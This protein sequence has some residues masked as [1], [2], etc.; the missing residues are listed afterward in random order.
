MRARVWRWTL[1]LILALGVAVATGPAHAASDPLDDAAYTAWVTQHAERVIAAV[2]L[3]EE[4]RLADLRDVVVDLGRLVDEARVVEPPPRYAAAH[5]RYLA[6]IDAVDRMRTSLL[7]VTVTRQ[8][9]TDLRDT[10]YAAG[11]AMAEGVQ[12]LYNAG[13]PLP[14][15]IQALLQAEN[16]DPAPR[17]SSEPTTVAGPTRAA[18]ATGETSASPTSRRPERA[19]TPRASCQADASCVAG[20]RLG[21]QVLGRADGQDAAR[22]MAAPGYQVVALRARIENVSNEAIV[23]R[24][25]QVRLRTADGRDVPLVHRADGQ[26]ELLPRAGL[27]LGPRESREGILYF[28]ISRD[29]RGQAIQVQD[30]GT[31]GRVL[32]IATP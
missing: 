32:S 31:P 8:P 22:V 30:G 11:Q 16:D 1:P 29:T 6:G 10:M 9:A 7:T 2:Q 13:I 5:S 27:P 23:V 14:S 28:T 21:I 25:N 15:R 20:S 3:P 19:P 4:F 17:A 18:P 26:G 24:S 12:E